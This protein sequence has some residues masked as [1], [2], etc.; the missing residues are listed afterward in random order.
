MRHHLVLAAVVAVCVA[1]T[2]VAITGGTKAAPGLEFVQ[3]GHWIYNSVLETA[4]HIDGASKNIDAQVR[5]PGA[6]PAT[7]VVQTDRKGYV[8][9]R[10]RIVEFGKSDLSV[11]DP[12]EPPADEQPIGLEASGAAY[13]VY[14]LAGTIARFGD[15]PVVAPVG[16]RIGTPV[17]TP[18]GTLWVHRLDGGQLCQLPLEA[19][20]LSCTATTPTGHTGGLTVVGDQAVFVD[21]TANA[22]RAVSEEGLGREIR[23]GL[24]L[25]DASVVAANDVKGR[26]A[27]VDPDRSVLHLID[28]ASAL[29]GEAVEPPISKRLRP[30]RYERVA[31]SGTALALID[32][33][34]DTVLT[35]DER[36]EVR[37]TARIPRIS[38]QEKA[39]RHEV[40]NGWP[41]ARRHSGR[42]HAHA[43]GE[44]GLFRGQD[45]RLYVDTATGE[46]VMVVEDDGDITPV[47]V[48]GVGSGHRGRSPH[49]RPS[50][51]SSHTPAPK[52]REPAERPEQKA[53]PERPAVRASRPGAP[54][55]VRAVAGNARIT[56]SWGG[57][58]D[59]GSPI[60]SYELSW[61]GGRKVVSGSSRTAV[62]R[63]LRNGSGYAITVRAVNAVGAGPG[64]TT[65]RVVPG[66]PAAAPPNF[67]VRAIS[68]DRHLFTWDRPAMG[69][70]TFVTY[71]LVRDHGANSKEMTRTSQTWGGLVEGRR[72]HF[73]VQAVTRSPSGELLYGKKSVLTFTADY[74][75]LGND[76]RVV[77]S[78]GAK[79]TYGDTCQEDCHFVEF[80]ATGLKPDTRYIFRVFSSEWGEFN[81]VI[82]TTDANGMEHEDSRFPCSATGQEVWIV[83]EGPDGP[84][85]SNRITW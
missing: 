82:L 20:R 40:G 75:N 33:D 35:L 73:T 37:R 81:R 50:D 41:N 9:S 61:Q 70:G 58:S 66:G 6:P 43:A 46:H 3:S 27:V 84:I 11:A 24:D 85:E 16:G 51:T 8:L 76:P 53:R 52:P 14:P 67:R 17:V 59:N 64:V 21:A 56:V 78:K 38:P 18:N 71:L 13:A 79:T 69:G 77:V 36:G 7:T 63:G 30:G 60:T 26:V 62:I 68:V 28:A 19:T 49:A 45:S 80:R 39:S 4:F 32:E 15:K 55:G 54:V 1:V 29:R 22:M 65:E 31:S 42:R 25:P 34:S 74:G 47:K 12:I 83:A 2:T 72:Y 44:P 23:V 57:A 48:D 10:D 5:V